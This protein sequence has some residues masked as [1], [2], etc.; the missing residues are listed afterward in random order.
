MGV[1]SKSLNARA[2]ITGLVVGLVV[3]L[4]LIAMG[5]SRVLGIHSGIIGLAFNLAICF[6]SIFPAIL[7]WGQSK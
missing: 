7:P 1:H 3:T 2:V 4:G 6:I 5:W